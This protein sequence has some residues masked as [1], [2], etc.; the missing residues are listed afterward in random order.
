MK[1][2]FILLTFLFSISMFSQGGT[3]P[4]YPR[5]EKD[6]T[7]QDV[8]VMTIKQA[9]KLDNNSDLLRLYE[10]LGIDMNNYENSCIKVIDDQ[11]KVIATLK[12]EINNLKSQI[13]IKDEKI[14]TLQKELADY[15]IKVTIL[16]KE[17]NNRQSLADERAKQLTKLKTKMIFGGIGGGVIIIGLVAAIIAH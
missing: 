7:G 2:L 9:M 15:V 4:T 17:V 14:L 1:K 16:E 11:N 13:F 5:I 6:S 3:A 12:L 8:V 10:Q